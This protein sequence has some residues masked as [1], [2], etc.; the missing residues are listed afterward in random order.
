MSHLR[1]LICRVEDESEQM[2]ELASVDLPTVLAH[3]AAAPLDRLEAHVATAGQRLLGRLCELQWDEVDA[4]AVA[5]YCAGTPVGSVWGDGYAVLTVA[6]RF[7]TL[8]LRRQICAH[9]DGRPHCMPGNDALPTHQGIVITRGLQEIACL[10]PQEVPFATAARLLGWQTG[11]PG[12]LSASTLR[13][14]VR[15]HGGRIR[16]IEQTEALLLLYQQQRGKRLRGVPVD[17]PRRRAGWPKELSAAVEAALEQGQARP[18]EGVSWSDW[19]R[20]LA[21]RAE[22]STQ[23]VT[24]LRRLGPE[25]APGQMLL[26]LDEVLT[27][28]PG[29]GQFQELRTACLLTADGRRYLSGRGIPFLRQVYAAVQTCCDQ[30]LLVVADGAGWIRTFFRDYLALLPQAEMVL[31]WHHL[32][33]KCRD[34]VRAICPAH[35]Q[36]VKLLHRLLRWLWAGNVPRALRV[37]EAHRSQAADAQAV[38]TLSAYL[39]ARVEWIPNYRARRRQRRYIGNGLG[40]KA[41]DRIVTRR[42]KRRGMQWGE[43]TSDGL[44]AL[45]TLALNEGWEE[46]WQQW[47]LIDLH[48]A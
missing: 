15:D 24:S 3:W 7:G 14:L 17:T 27:R 9:R 42:Q 28:A 2:T 47:Q 20:V 35:A 6:S 10:L 25:L 18:P 29:Q 13:T 30:S 1:V 36:R 43:Q 11:E 48:A 16:R 22:D 5:R 31:D 34:L 38:E 46:Y 39:S 23:S 44:A 12:L 33:Q 32:A 40:E 45:R 21:A 37:L 8:H 19:T 41:N 26:V 4:Q